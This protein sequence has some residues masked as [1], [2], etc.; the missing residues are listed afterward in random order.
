MRA[1]YQALHNPISLLGSIGPPDRRLLRQ[2]PP[3]FPCLTQMGTV[4][5]HVAKTQKT[6]RKRKQIERIWGFQK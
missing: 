2:D 3:L 6:G 1:P 4:P 5:P